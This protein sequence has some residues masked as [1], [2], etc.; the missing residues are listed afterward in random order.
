[1]TPRARLARPSQAS[2]QFTSSKMKNLIIFSFMLIFI[3]L[4]SIV[5]LSY[6]WNS[7]THRFLSESVIAKD[8]P[9]CIA[10]IKNGSTFPDTTIKDFVNHHCS[11]NAPDCKARL[12]AN[13]WLIKNFSTECEHAFNLAV[14]SHYFADS[15]S[16]AHW[17]S[18][19][20]CHSKFENCVDANII[21]GGKCWKCIIK[22]NDKKGIERILIANYSHMKET[23]NN[24]ALNLNLSAPFQNTAE[25]CSGFSNF[26]SRIINFIS[27]IF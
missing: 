7:E 3:V 13:E 18:L 21:S 5:P 16:P 11:D 2:P 27:K 15:Y 9:D 25:N 6:A 8:F 19:E 24:I 17:Y 12:N 20:D 26:I 1:M 10:E 22:C 4:P 23:A 14:A